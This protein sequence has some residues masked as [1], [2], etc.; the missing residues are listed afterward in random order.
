MGEDEQRSE[1]FYR[2]ASA[3]GTFSPRAGRQHAP[4]GRLVQRA[5]WVRLT[6]RLVRGD[7][8]A[9]DMRSRSVMGPH[10]FQSDLL[11]RQAFLRTLVDTWTDAVSGLTGGSSAG[12]A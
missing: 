9:L 10:S 8:A 2:A 5:G 1:R 6:T 11:V 3:Y 7:S 4:G 12:A